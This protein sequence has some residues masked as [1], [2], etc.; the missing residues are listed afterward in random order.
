MVVQQV[1][2][3]RQHLPALGNISFACGYTI[4]ALLIGSVWLGRTTSYVNLCSWLP[5]VIGYCL[6]PL[7]QALW[8]HPR[9]L[10]PDTIG[11]GPRWGRYHRLLL[12]LS[13]PAQL[14][15]L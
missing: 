15:M 8:P 5:L 10:L 6:V 13:L 4:P 9:P 11:D 2:P 14:T 7:L 3:T 1:S 12:W